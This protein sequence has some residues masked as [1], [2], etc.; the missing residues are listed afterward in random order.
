VLLALLQAEG[1]LVDFLQQ[2]ISDFDDVDVGAAARVVHQGCGKVL[3]AHAELEPVRSEAEDTAVEIAE[4]YDPAEIKLT[5]ALSGT[6]P[7]R[8]ILRHAG[9][10]ARALRLPRCLSAHDPSVLAPAEIEL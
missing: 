9:W 2:D 4:G 10:R 6:P 8:G 3:S 1:R 7:Y 5:G